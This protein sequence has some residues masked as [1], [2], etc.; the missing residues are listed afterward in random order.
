M[1]KD[2]KTRAV[3]YIVKLILTPYQPTRLYQYNIIYISYI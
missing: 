2:L 1:R 3:D